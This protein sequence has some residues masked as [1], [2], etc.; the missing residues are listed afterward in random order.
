MKFDQRR[1]IILTMLDASDMLTIQQITAALG[2]SEATA[3]RD[4]TRMEQQGDLVRCWGGVQRADTP[5]NKRRHTLETRR[6]G[7]EH[8]IVGRVAAEQVKDGD[9]IFVGSGIS[10]LAMIPYI[11]AANVCA[12]T[13]AVPQ[14]EALDRAGIKTFLLCGYFKE[15]SRSLVGAETVAML[16][17]YRFDKAF[18]GAR[19]MSE[20]FAL[21]SGDAYEAELKSAAIGASGQTFLLLDHSKFDRTAL[22]STPAADVQNVVV[23]TDRTDVVSPSWERVSGGYMSR[24]GDLH[25]IE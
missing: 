1:E 20:E 10:T 25:R 9:T 16:K 17:N 2:S 13:N 18:I 19:G 14:L 7:P 3:R 22:Y 15:Y 5:E 4:V 8:L 6:P 12:V 21:L 23:I 24:V 11:Q